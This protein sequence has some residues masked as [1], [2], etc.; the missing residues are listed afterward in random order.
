MTFNNSTPLAAARSFLAAIKTKDVVTM[1]RLSHPNG[2]ACLIRNGAPTHM[3]ISEPIESIGAADSELDEV[4]Y[5]EVEHIDG[6]YATIWTPYRFY[7]DGMVGVRR[8]E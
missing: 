5:N 7:E 6:I 1:K 3:S 4:S 8:L 2:T